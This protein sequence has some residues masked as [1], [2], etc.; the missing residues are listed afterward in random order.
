MK[1]YVKLLDWIGI[2]SATL[3]LIH[4]LLF[5]LLTFIPIGLTHN[6]FVDFVFASIGLFV[7]IK[8]VRTNTQNYVKLILI[9]SITL[10]FFS[11]IYSLLTDF[12]TNIL[13]FGG[14]GMVLGH[15]LNFKFHKHN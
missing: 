14:V 6:H 4:C 5:P 12:H 3:C 8:I 2:S 15:I 9:A 10:I 1:N 7:V 13:Y 11:I